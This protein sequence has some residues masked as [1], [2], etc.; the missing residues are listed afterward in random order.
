MTSNT[1]DPSSVIFG[2]ISKYKNEGIDSFLQIETCLA[3]YSRCQT[4]S[5][6][7]ENFNF[8]IEKKNERIPVSW[9]CAEILG[10]M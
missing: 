6:I 8:N 3:I 7:L 10:V 1:S 4:K 2:M 5:K 9:Q